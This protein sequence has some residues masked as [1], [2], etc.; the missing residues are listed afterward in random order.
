M[1]KTDFFSEMNCYISVD[2]ETAGPNPSDYAMLSIGA[3]TIMHP[4]QTFYCELKPDRGKSDPSALE[5]CRLSMD[6]LQKN[7]IDP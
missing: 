1:E 5:I 7:G 2:V 4:R 6:E 3:C